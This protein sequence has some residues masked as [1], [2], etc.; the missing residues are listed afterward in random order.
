MVD[1]TPLKNFYTPDIK[2]ILKGFLWRRKQKQ[3][4]QQQRQ[5]QRRQQQQYQQIARNCWYRIIPR[6][7][8][9]FTTT[10]QIRSS[11]RKMATTVN[12]S[13]LCSAPWDTTMTNMV[14]MLP[15]AA[16][17]Y[18]DS[19]TASQNAFWDLSYP[20]D[21]GLGRQG[22]DHPIQKTFGEISPCPDDVCVLALTILLSPIPH[23]IRH[24]L[25]L[26]HQYW[27]YSVIVPQQMGSAQDNGIVLSASAADVDLHEQA[28]YETAGSSFNGGNLSSPAVGSSASSSRKRKG[29]STSD[30]PVS[31]HS[32]HSSSPKSNK[33]GRDRE[34]NRVVRT[35]KPGQFS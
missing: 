27:Q 14:D 2:R 6:Q 15:Y 19:L 28:G 1:H 4:Q 17:Q 31:E 3:Q 11:N 8:E 26:T 20:A 12:C 32:H 7:P 30:T 34:R 9:H 13:G 10:R 33:T 16:F 22:Q 25:R 5:Q 23:K 21:E 29:P 18:D 24:I 35:A